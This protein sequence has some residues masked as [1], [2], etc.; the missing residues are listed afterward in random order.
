MSVCD[1]TSCGTHLKSKLCGCWM[2]SKR[3][4]TGIVVRN[5][6]C[7]RKGRDE[8]Y[9]YLFSL[10]F[11]G[12][13]PASSSHCLIIFEEIAFLPCQAQNK[14]FYHLLFCLF[15]HCKTNDLQTYCTVQRLLFVISL[16]T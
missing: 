12:E 2:C 3:F 6:H 1:F 10:Q 15:V 4:P 16:Q 14:T 13:L 7:Q 8:M 11:K 9:S 5:V